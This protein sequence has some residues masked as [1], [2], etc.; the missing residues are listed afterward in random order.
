MLCLHIAATSLACVAAAPVPARVF[1]PIDLAFESAAQPANPFV[2]RFEGRCEGPGGEALTLP[3]FYD[4]NGTCKLRFAPTRAG[5]WTVT[6]AS[7]DPALDGRTVSIQAE[8][9]PASHGRLRVDPRNPRR[10]A[11]EDGSPF[12]LTGY[13][14]DWLWA[15]DLG[16]APG[17][18]T[19]GPFLDKLA[20]SG[21]N[22]VVMNA[23]AHDTDWRPGKTEDAD[24][25]PP[26]LF[27][28]AGTNDAPDH[29][30][31]NLEYWRHYDDIV[32]A[33]NARA[34]QAH[35]MIKVYNKHVNWPER[36]SPEERLYL[37][38]LIARYSAFLNIVW[39]FSKESY[40]EKDL[41]YKLDTLR[42][43]RETDPYHHLMTAHDDDGPYDSGAYDSLLDFQSDQQHDHWHE[44]ILRQSGRKAWPVLNIE[45]GYECGP[46]GV[47]DR[48]YGVAQ[49]PEEVLARAWRVCMAGG[50]PNYYYTR[51]AWDVI[52]PED[53]PPG[54]AMMGHLRAFFEAAGFRELA[55]ADE[56]VSSGY[57]LAVRGRR[58]VAYQSAA[59]PF[60]L[61]A[62]G[63]GKLTVRWYQCLTGTWQD[64]GSVEPGKLRLVPPAA[65]AGP[66]AVVVEGEA[67]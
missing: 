8:V 54:Y 50:Y 39:D 45:F 7:E 22:Y 48:T 56:L 64:G 41:Q 33:M 27:A 63:E 47:E 42:F 5:E 3:G 59:Q 34:L 62:D 30:R 16:G 46:G 26:A 28:W 9:N 20:A 36:R 10:F 35:I 2:V 24:Y 15:L 1:E 23:Y 53:T 67:R 49:V 65:W 32:R 11:F 19:A 40:N 61:E 44:T 21:F 66:V 25:G 13:E 58:Y 29:R 4:G 37:A 31:M 17:L 60:E 51:T 55:P 12:L 38:W 18:P 57:C 43:I 52:H 14:C 6:T